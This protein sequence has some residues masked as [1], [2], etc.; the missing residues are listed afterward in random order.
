MIK[1]TLY[2]GNPAYLHLR[3][4]QLVIELP[5][6]QGMAELTKKNTVPIEDIGVIV[7]DHK[8]ITF[9]HSLINALLANNAAIITCDERHHPVGLMLPLDGLTVQ[10]ER[11][12]AQIDG[13]LPL[14]K[15]LWTQTVVAKLENQARALQSWGCDAE[16][17]WHWAKQLRSGDP[18][19][20]EARAAAYYWKNFLPNEF[21]FYRLREGDYPNSL[22]NYGYAIVRAV[23]ARAL[24]GSGLLPTLGIFHRNKYNAYC[25]ADDMMEPYRP[26]W[27]CWCENWCLS[28]SLYLPN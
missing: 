11:F 8:Q 22:L 21:Q 17:V 12:K 9:S 18:D 25:L 2:F 20:F 19:N 3:N 27:M 26:M 14:K 6:D 7:F 15:Q 4:D 10:T 23:V 16:P 13:S 1:R 24:V 28:N 5:N